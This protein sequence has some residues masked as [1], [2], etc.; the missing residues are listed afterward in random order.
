MV[1]LPTGIAVECQSE[2]SQIKN[3][4]IALKKL[5]AKLCQQHMDKEVKCHSEIPH[6][7]DFIK[8]VYCFQFQ[9][10]TQIATRKTQ[11]GSS[12]RNEKIRTYNFNQDRIT[13]HRLASGGTVHNLVGVLA[14]GEPLDD[15]IRKLEAESSKRQIV[16]MI[17]SV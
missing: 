9:L 11:V 10:A 12:L 7:L 5:Q 17:E 15:L 8:N 1:H 16:E 3:R 13:D 6:K 14:G 2:R 4:E